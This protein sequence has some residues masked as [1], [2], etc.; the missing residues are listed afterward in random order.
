M[1]SKSI[2]TS[3]LD[4]LRMVCTRMGCNLRVEMS[5]SFVD[6]CVKGEITEKPNISVLKSYIERNVSQVEYCPTMVLSLNG[7]TK[8]FLKSI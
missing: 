6:S 1:I 7:N 8:L 3:S 2:P 5:Y 4:V